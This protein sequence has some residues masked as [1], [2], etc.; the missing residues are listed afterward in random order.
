MIKMSAMALPL[1]IVTTSIHSAQAQSLIGGNIVNLFA[2]PSDVVVELD[3]K[4]NCGNPSSPYFH[5]QRAR[6]NFR[7]MTAIALT[8]FSTGKPIAFFVASCAADR[9]IISHGF[10]TH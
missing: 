2:D 5:I 9:T 6:A 8:A 4:G 10:I 3:K 7:E 1:L